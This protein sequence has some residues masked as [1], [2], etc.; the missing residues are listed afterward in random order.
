LA[1]L[2]MWISVVDECHHHPIGAFGRAALKEGCRSP[3]VVQQRLDVLERCFGPLFVRARKSDRVR[4]SRK[5]K[6]VPI[7][8]SKGARLA[9][10]FAT[11]EHLY[12]IARGSGAMSL[13]GPIIDLKKDVLTKLP[14]PIQRAF[15]EEVIGRKH[16]QAVD[17][18]S[19]PSEGRNRVNRTRA[20][21]HRLRDPR[22]QGRPLYLIK[23]MKPPY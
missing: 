4:D 16:Q 22:L 1:D 7:P 13:E 23:P 5:A 15:D 21:M 6:R 9:E 8:N 20:W 14:A 17:L 2:F 10:I 18:R 12:S 3:S 11:V 19:G